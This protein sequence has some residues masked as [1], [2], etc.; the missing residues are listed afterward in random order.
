MFCLVSLVQFTAKKH[1]V[2]KIENQPYEFECTLTGTQQEI[3]NSEISWCKPG[4]SGAEVK[5]LQNDPEVN[6][7]VK[8]GEI[9]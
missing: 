8:K 2:F 4:P 3:E 1:E 9:P 6:V 7:T 5:V